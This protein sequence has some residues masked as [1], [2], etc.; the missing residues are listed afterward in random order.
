MT[1]KLDYLMATAY[2]LQQQYI[3]PGKYKVEAEKKTYISVR[4]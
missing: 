4:D 2:S 3:I 1:I